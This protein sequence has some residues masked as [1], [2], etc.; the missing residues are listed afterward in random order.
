MTNDDGKNHQTSRSLP[1]VNETADFSWDEDTVPRVTD[2]ILDRVTVVPELPSE[3]L[4][5]R[6]MLEVTQDPSSEMLEREAL[7]APPGGKQPAAREL[8]LDEKALDSAVAARGRW[9]R[10]AVASPHGTSAPPQSLE[11]DLSALDAQGPPSSDPA[12]RELNDRYAMGDYSGALVVAEGVLA[13]DPTH[14]D[15]LRFARNCQ[16]VLT[17][18]YS[19]RLGPLDQIVSVGLPCE[20]VRWLSLDHRSGFLLSLVDGC[21]TIDEILDISGMPKLDALR[22]MF[23]LF[24]ERIIALRARG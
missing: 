6:L 12:L 15:A 23:S 13:Q 18:M 22:I 24:Q 19:A 9:R 4:A 8:E 20:Q 2:P 16:E 14:S 7:L 5:K 10:A 21:S 1:P 11:L 3:V 17:S